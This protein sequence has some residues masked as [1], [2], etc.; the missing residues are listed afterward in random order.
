VDVFARLSAELDEHPSSTLAAVAARLQIHRHT[1]TE[2]VRARTGMHFRAWRNQRR[3]ERCCQLLR[4]RGTLSIKEISSLAGFSSTTAFDRFIKR[5]AGCRPSELNPDHV[6][7]SAVGPSVGL[8][9][10]QSARSR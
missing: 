9:D 10:N 4:D 7:G 1:V 2:V 6:N 3:F 8:F 5:C